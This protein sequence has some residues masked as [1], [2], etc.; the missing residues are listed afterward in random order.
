M[1][2]AT[3]RLL[4]IDD[5][6]QL[7]RTLGDI[8]KVK[9]Y[10]ALTAED[11]TE[12]LSL[13]GAG[14]VDLALI[15]L[16]L[17]DIGGL[18]LLE[19][20]RADFPSTQAIVLTGDASV[21]SA[22]EA[23]HRGAFSY[24]VKPCAMDQLLLQIRR[25]VEKGRAEAQLRDAQL[26]QQRRTVELA[27]EIAERKSTEAALR[28]SN[29]HLR[30]FSE[31]NDTLVHA[32][33]ED[34]L[35]ES[36]CAKIVELGNYRLA[37][38]GYIA[39]PAEEL[40]PVTH[41]LHPGECLAVRARGHGQSAAQGCP[42]ARTMEQGGGREEGRGLEKAYA[43]WLD[44]GSRYGCAPAVAFP[45]RGEKGIFGVLTIHTAE[46]AGFGTEET[47][48][49][50]ELASHLAFGIQSL[51]TSAERRR[52][53]EVLRQRQ[54]AIEA[55]CNGIMLTG[56]APD[57]A[58]ILYVNPA[59][60]RLT[61][62]AAQ[63]M[64]GGGFGFLGAEDQEQMGL[65]EVRAALREQRK[66]QAVLRH[67]RR[68]G[69]LFWTELSVSPVRDEQGRVANFVW[70]L[71]DI[72][73]RKHYEE[74]LEHQANHDGLTGLAN[75]NLLTDRI[76]QA[77]SYAGR[78]GKQAALLFINLD[79]FKDLNDSLGYDAGDLLLKAVAERL[80]RC[81]RAFDTV[82]RHGG[83]EFVVVLPDLAAGEEAA[84]IAK[85]IRESIRR[86]FA[87]AGEEVLVTCSTGISLFPKDGAEPQSLLQNANVAM[88]RAKEQDR[89]SSQ[90]YTCEMNERAIARLTME[91]CL[92]RALER[93]ELLLHYQPQVDLET[94]RILGVEALLRW[95]SPELGLVPPARFIPLAEETGLIVPL[96]EWVLKTVCAQAMAW[97]RSGLSPLV[98]AVNLSPRQFWQQGLPATVARVL[99]E[100]GLEPRWLE[101][102][103]IE[104]LVMHDM[105]SARA[106]LQQL[107]E[108][109]VQLSMDD[110]GTGYSSLS[111]LKRFPFDKIKIDQ[112][113]VHDITGDPDSAA[114]ARAIIAMGHSL[115][116]RVIAE[117]VETEGQLGYLRFH[118]C[119]E[120][121]GYF[122]SRPAPPEDIARMLHDHRA[123]D[124]AVDEGA[125]AERTLLL[126]D[127]EPHVLS[128]FRRLLAD[129]DY[130]VLTAASAAEGFE[131]LAT[132]RIGVV[133][134]DLCM[135]GMNGTEFL[136]RVKELHAD[137][138][139]ILLSGSADLG[140][141]SDAI[142][143]G[144]IFKFFIKPWENEILRE[145]IREA[146]RRFRLAKGNGIC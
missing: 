53:G 48:L 92:R 24:V 88:H 104:S 112:S 140:S 42:V 16:S 119:D 121:Q 36:I 122:F 11:G 100:T 59:F 97:R 99:A 15:D 46:G 54:R 136:S 31:C 69:R 37:W 134:S 6:A 83:D 98:V 78:Y 142:N 35:L 13:L 144:A 111:Y 117:G 62:Y 139:R 113:F 74:Q 114:I 73:E 108:L 66:G 128:A 47:G 56:A 41:A 33:C 10:E 137:A 123:L 43:A 126:V 44:E 39:D 93:E 45:L 91:K 64:P 138:I 19:R 40:T 20:I 106:T 133:V 2:L 68:D 86:P 1:K 96:G 34:G 58:P 76:D 72:T 103:I 146:F 90:F 22:V 9:G 127:D 141:L 18:E 82:A 25:A 12:G 27:A 85:Q 14:P 4:I 89:G 65:A 94:G 145:N 143:R 95:Q 109:G 8:L 70:I 29:R 129:D 60:E 79:N 52:A 67:R 75:R 105:E 115:N 87:I 50:N 63:E 80:G 132:R 81:V 131:L 118:G 23:T 77:L 120:M 51:R 116:L 7:R 107:K 32:V 135:P 102:E 57:E 61:G 3:P 124:L 55:S 130:H 110:F 26:A 21:E 17:P 38:V 125:G 49:L 84:T 28:R 5:D 30:L 101:L 71:N